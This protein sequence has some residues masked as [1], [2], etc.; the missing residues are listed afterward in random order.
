MYGI[1][2]WTEPWRHPWKTRRLFD[3]YHL[4]RRF[5]FVTT[6][7]ISTTP[8][9]ANTKSGQLDEVEAAA[10]RSRYLVR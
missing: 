1:P 3:S 6:T 9:R 4:R 8:P 7:M 2:C 10:P 5:K